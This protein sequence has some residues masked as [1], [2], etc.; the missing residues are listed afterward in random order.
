MRKD[1]MGEASYGETE[2][3]MPTRFY[4]FSPPGVPRLGRD[5]EDRQIETLAKQCEQGK[6]H[7]LA[8]SEHET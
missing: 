3:R 4:I 1:V 8:A 7:E 2:T 6:G 5:Q